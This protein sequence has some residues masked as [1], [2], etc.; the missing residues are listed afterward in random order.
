[1]SE[2]RIE[3]NRGRDVEKEKRSRKRKNGVKNTNRVFLID[4]VKIA[5][6]T[7]FVVNTVLRIF[8]CVCGENVSDGAK[9]HQS[10]PILTNTGS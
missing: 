2:V 3:R 4:F 5:P 9:A 1:M 7:K 8:T 10:Q 6:V